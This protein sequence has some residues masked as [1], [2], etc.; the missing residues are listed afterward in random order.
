M[1]GQH[2]TIERTMDVP[3]FLN[4]AHKII[5]A[6][7]LHAEIYDVEGCFPNMPKQHISFA[8][9]Q[10]LKEIELAT[11]RDSVNLSLHEGQPKSV[12]WGMQLCNM[13]TLT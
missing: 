6:G 10:V 7:D 9:R 12:N 11:G 4:D 3:Q 1:P 8:L 5:G 13:P 2:F